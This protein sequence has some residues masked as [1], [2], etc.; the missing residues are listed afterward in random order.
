[1]TEA[2]RSLVVIDLNVKLLGPSQWWELGLYLTI[3]LIEDPQAIR[4]D[5]L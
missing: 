3:V 4:F 5:D 2:L 1:M